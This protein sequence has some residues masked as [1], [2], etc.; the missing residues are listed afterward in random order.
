M[1]LVF[2]VTMIGCVGTLVLAVWPGALYQAGFCSCVALPL[3]IPC[4]LLLTLSVIVRDLNRKPAPSSPGRWAV[5]SVVAVVGTTGLVW[6][7]IPQL[8][9]FAVVAGSMQSL[10]QTAPVANPQAIGFEGVELDRRFGPYRVD[11]YAADPRGG[12]YFRT[13]TGPDGIG[14]DRMSYGFAFRPNR[15]ARRSVRLRTTSITSSG[16][17]TCSRHRTT[18]SK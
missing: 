18:I 2:A 12:V 3:L 10:V 8:I 15:K 7:H 13:M 9:A 1:L 11:R 6:Y 4:L 14:P 5:L 17:G 16:T